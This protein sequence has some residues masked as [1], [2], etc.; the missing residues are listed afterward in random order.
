MKKIKTLSKDVIDR[1]EIPFDKTQTIPIDKI[2]IKPWLK[3]LIRSRT[4]LEKD[5]LTADIKIN[6]LST[7][8]TL[9]TFNGEENCLVDGHGRLESY[10]KLGKCR[11]PYVVVDFKNK[12]AIKAWVY[13]KQLGRRNLTKQDR[14]YLLGSLPDSKSKLAEKFG[15][16]KTQVTEY[17]KYFQAVEWLITNTDCK[18]ENLLNSTLTSVINKYIKRTAELGGSETDPPKPKFKV[19]KETQQVLT[20]LVEEYG[21]EDVDHL[22]YEAIDLIR[23]HKNKPS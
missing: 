18:K 20:K 23:T 1:I 19:K 9:T 8:I 15:V 14:A 4:E 2:I 16:S 11:I 22:I 12:D 21:Y 7:P 5:N 6:G 10:L 13:R 3:E 17:R